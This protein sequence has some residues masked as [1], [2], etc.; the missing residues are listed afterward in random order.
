MATVKRAVF[1]CVWSPN[2]RNPTVRHPSLESARGEALRLAR[3]NPGHDFYV[4]HAV[5]GFHRPSDDLRIE[6]DDGIPF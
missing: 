6:L 1:W 5:D 4:L 3:C 2:G